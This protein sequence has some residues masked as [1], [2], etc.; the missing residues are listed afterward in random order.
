MSVCIDRCPR[1]GRR[2]VRVRER[3]IGNRVYLYA[4]HYEGGRKRECYLGPKDRYEYVSRLHEREN[5]A[6]R[7]LVDKF[8]AIQYLE[9][10]ASFL[11]ETDDVEL[12]S[13]ALPVLRQA[14]SCVERK[15]RGK[16]RRD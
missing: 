2:V 11:A 16:D 5:L 4:V 10:L 3:R 15:I 9:S 13:E 6:L 7:G 12:L 8:R 1:C 14:T